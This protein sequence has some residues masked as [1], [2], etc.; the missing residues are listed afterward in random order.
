M[1]R[2]RLALEEALPFFRLNTQDQGAV[3]ENKS[4]RCWKRLISNRCLCLH[5]WG[6]ISIVRSLV[7]S[8]AG[9]AGWAMALSIL[10]DGWS[11]AKGVFEL[12]AGFYAYLQVRTSLSAHTRT[13][14]EIVALRS[15]K[16][17]QYMQECLIGIAWWFFS[18]SLS[19]SIRK[20][21]R[22]QSLWRI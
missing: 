6:G 13:S 3:R 9:L 11:L 7:L 1:N 5:F 12:G 15:H 16:R 10:S 4:I 2:T 19:L 8:L 14:A 18:L 22:S 20:I 17:Y 21:R